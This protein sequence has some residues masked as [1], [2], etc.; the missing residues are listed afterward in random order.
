MSCAEDLTLV[1]G[2]K[3]VG[4]GFEGRERVGA[5]IHIRHAVCLGS[6]DKHV[7]PLASVAKGETLSP[8]HINVI[9]RT[10]VR[11]G[12]W[13]F[14]QPS[15]SALFVAKALG[16]PGHASDYFFAVGTF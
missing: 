12:G 5:G 9:Q 13:H 8:W 11:A 15:F 3:P 16:G 7:E 6:Y 1:A 4:E 2:Q 10:E 14:G